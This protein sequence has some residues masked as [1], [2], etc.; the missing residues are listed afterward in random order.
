[1]GGKG[2][3]PCA[4]SR[5][6]SARTRRKP[7]TRVEAERAMGAGVGRGGRRR[8]LTCARRRRLEGRWEEH[9]IGLLLLVVLASRAGGLGLSASGV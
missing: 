8:E 6:R 4:A 9:S 7:A 1:V 5:V 2:C 3:W